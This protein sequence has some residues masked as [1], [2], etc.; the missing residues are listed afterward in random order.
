VFKLAPAAAAAVVCCA[1]ALPVGANEAPL[2]D[3]SVRQAMALVETIL[4]RHDID[5]R[6]YA[7]TS[8][9]QIERVDASHQIL[10]GN[11]GGYVDGRIYLN[12]AVIED[13]LQLT[14]VHELVHDASFKHRLFA[15]VPNARIRNVLEALA[16]AVTAVAA[17]DPYLPGCLPQRQFQVSAADLASLAG[18][19]LRR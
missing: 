2:S 15:E 13:C 19:A 16:D 12:D 18:P 5:V 7:Q 6:G 10:Q 3:G 8:P 11:D 4:A 1:A 14:L 17:E 9:P